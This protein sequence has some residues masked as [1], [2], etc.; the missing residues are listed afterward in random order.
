MLFKRES[1]PSHQGTSLRNSQP[2]ASK[3]GS[4]RRKSSSLL[5][6]RFA[7]TVCSLKELACSRRRDSGLEL[8]ARSKSS[9]VL[10][11]KGSNCMLAQ[12]AR[13]FSLRSNPRRRIDAL[14]FGSHVLAAAALRA[15]TR[16][17]PSG[18]ACWLVFDSN[19]MLAQRA[20]MFSLRSNPRGH[21]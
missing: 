19:W 16:C 3:G 14:A 11:L 2:A 1:T 18:L 5:R 8:Y 17:S 7:R 13:M 10:A 9:H 12:R 15:R 21:K 20:R 6:S 4:T